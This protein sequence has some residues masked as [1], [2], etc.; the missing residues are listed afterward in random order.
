[1]K[2]SQFPL[3]FALLLLLGGCGAPSATKPEEAAEP[4]AVAVT[5]AKAAI[6]PIRDTVLVDGSFTTAEGQ[7]ARLAP[8]LAGRIT[9]ILV[10]EG[11]HVTAGQLLATIDTRVQAAQ[12][13]GAKAAT[14]AATAQMNQAKVNLQV[15]AEDTNL[16]I[17]AAELAYAS[18]IADRD[19]SVA[20]AKA[21]L[22]RIRAGARPQEIAQAE[23]SVA[24][25]KLVRD[26]AR[27][28]ADRDAALLKEGFVSGQQA[29]ISQSTYNVAFSA[30]RQ[31]EAQL[32]LLKAGARPED[33]RAAEQRLR[34]LVDVGQRK[35]AL[36]KAAITQAMAARASLR[37]KALDVISAQ[38]TQSQRQDDSIASAETARNGEIR[39]PFSGVIMRRMA[40]PGDIGDPT[41][42]I[43]EMASLDSA[44]DFV[45]A[46]DAETTQ[47]LQIG[48]PAFI[49]DAPDRMGKVTSIG[50]ANPQSGLVSV[51]VRFPRLGMAGLP[52]KFASA[53]IIR[54]TNPQAITVPEAAI[55][56][57]EDKS[58]VF[59]VKDGIAK[60]K[61]VTVGPDE[62]GL[63]TISAGVA[64]GD[65]LVLLGHHELADGAK[66]EVTKPG[67][68]K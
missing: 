40:N 22:V 61:E 37:S 36:A 60:R 17:R 6:H 2:L 57:R 25:A 47:R 34:G 66:V 51:R 31:A 3:I 50:S 27:H 45:G 54:A 59:I 1:M 20:D 21:D 19:S 9:K 4:A 30:L 14:S 13:L 28:D 42:P 65:E 58:V 29:E 67:Q 35:V 24:Q 8:A 52:G 68:E 7:S 16:A 39:A 48:M 38:A 5:T 56:L 44:I 53:R 26:R 18:A 15:A 10:R 12:S 41:L 64:I 46:A 43:L 23:Q 63:V 55:L 49:S 33:V 11:D 62:E 32:D